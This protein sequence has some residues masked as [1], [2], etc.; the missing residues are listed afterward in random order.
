MGAT[1]LLLFALGFCTF[2][3]AIEATV[4]NSFSRNDTERYNHLVV[5]E[6]TGRVYIGAVNYIFQLSNTLQLQATLITGPKDDSPECPITGDCQSATKRPTDNVNKALVID[7]SKGYLIACGSIFQGVCTVRR[8]NNI[9][10]LELDS[11]M[12]AVVANNVTASTFAF[13]APGPPSPPETHVLYVGVS[14]TGNGPYRSEVPAVSS[15]SLDPNNMFAIS[16]VS[17]TTG[18]RMWVN[19]LERERY[20]ITYVFGFHSR[21]FSYFMTTQK[22]STDKKAFISK[23]IRL[24]HNDKD[25]Y[26]YTEI[27]IECKSK[28]GVHYNLV[29]AGFMGKPGS[30]LARDL[31]ITAQDEALFAV[32]SKSSDEMDV[33][34][35]PSDQSALCVFSIKNIH[36]KFTENIQQCFSGMGDRGL[37]F[38]SPSVKCYETV[39]SFFFRH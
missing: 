18:T 34:N 24:C 33:Y 21:G 13:V 14:Y 37:N 32:F 11:S 10:I 4:V 3:K 9:T 2:F 23:L 28:D 38:I 22:E 20:P 25:Y 1:T 35:R 36:R 5:D 15:R 17:V 7:S 30:E 29:Q 26:S 19:S 8:L 6:H 27:P 39:S 12:E 16:S 31:G